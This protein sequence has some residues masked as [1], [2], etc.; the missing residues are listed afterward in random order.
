MRVLVT[1]GAGYIGSHTMLEIL[2]ADHTPL[3][4]DNFSNASPV[5]L[6]RVA[7]LSNRNFNHREANLTDGASI[8][9]IVEEFQPQAVIHFAGLKAV[10]ESEQKPLSY[11]EENV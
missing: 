1:G 5:A 9:Q 6:E 8:R 3:V 2:A 4:V 7:R 11:Y 10:G